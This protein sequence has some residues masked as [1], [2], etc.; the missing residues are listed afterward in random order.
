[1]SNRADTTMIINQNDLKY[2]FNKRMVQQ[3]PR[4]ML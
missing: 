3:E 4:Q 2:N 1:M